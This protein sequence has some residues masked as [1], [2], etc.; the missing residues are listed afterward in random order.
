MSATAAPR[1]TSDAAG[2]RR[3]LLVLTGA[4]LV[5]AIYGALFTV[6]VTEYGV[7]SRFGHIVRVV[8]TPGLHL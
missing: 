4:L 5:A 7:V 2:W 8:D 3:L 6:V 1:T